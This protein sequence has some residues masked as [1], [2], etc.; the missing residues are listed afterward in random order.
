MN[1][2]LRFV[3]EEEKWRKGEEKKRNEKNK[4]QRTG[5]LGFIA[6]WKMVS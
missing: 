3:K 1:E 2:K 4:Y 5:D 6:K